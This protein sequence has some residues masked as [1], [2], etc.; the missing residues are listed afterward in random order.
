MKMNITKNAQAGTFESSDILILV[1]PADDR[2][3]EL[4]STVLLQYKEDILA[5][6]N[7]V[8]DQFDVSGIRLI[9][10]DKGALNGTI[11]ARVETAILRG[12]GMQKG[13]S[14]ESH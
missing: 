7:E 2:N 6:I 1:E 5:K 10:K 9:A 4:D 12:A 11:A 3:I 13:T 14:Y 8:L